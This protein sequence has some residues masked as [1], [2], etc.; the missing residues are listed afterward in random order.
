MKCV[1]YK[2][3][4]KLKLNICFTT[5]IWRLKTFSFLFSLL[6][7]KEIIFWHVNYK[8]LYYYKGLKKGRIFPEFMKS[9][10]STINIEPVENFNW[11]KQWPNN[12][13][14]PK[15]VSS[16][17]AYFWY[18]I[19]SQCSVVDDW[20]WSAVRPDVFFCNVLYINPWFNCNMLQSCNFH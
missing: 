1:H 11:G 7:S 8:D 9:W 2:L 13:V 17:L 6:F 14:L 15:L 4:H 16:G 18:R 12:Q 20:N 19:E 3:C 5:V 10:L